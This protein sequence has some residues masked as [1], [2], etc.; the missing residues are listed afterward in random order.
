MSRMVSTSRRRP[1]KPRSSSTAGSRRRRRRRRRR[2]RRGW[3][4]V[5]D[6]RVVAVGRLA[7]QLELGELGGRVAHEV[8]PG[9]V[10][11]VLR[12]RREQL[13]EDLG[14][15]AVG[16]PLDGPH[17]V[18]VQA[19]AGGE[20][21]R[22][23]VGAPVGEHREHVL[24]DRV[25]VEGLGVRR[26]GRRARRRRRRAP[27]CSSS[28]AVTQHR[29]RRPLGL[30]ARQVRIEVVGEEVAH[31]VAQL[32]DGLHAVRRAATGRPPTPRS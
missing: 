15:V 22:R 26:P 24:P 28:A 8:H 5:V 2:A 23:P 4:G 6:H 17:V 7:R 32:V 18:L 11:A 20:G 25:G 10:P 30:V 12:A 14:G 29:H 27:S 9:A 21:V 16:Q 13:G 1:T 19:V 3:P 31:E